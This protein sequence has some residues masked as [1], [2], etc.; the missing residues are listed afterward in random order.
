[1]AD[2]TGTVLIVDD[3][4]AVIEQLAAHFRRRNC[5]P[6][7]TA[8]PLIVEQSL[9]T[10]QIDLIL[11]D[12]RMERLNGYDVLQKLREKKMKI[13]ILIITAYYEDEKERLKKI[14][15]KQTDII[16]KPFQD[17]TKIEALINQKLNRKTGSS[18]ASDYDDAIY[19][20]NRTK[21]VLA[22][23]EMELCDVFKEILQARKYHLKTFT[24]GD[25]ALDYLLHNECHIAIID[26]KLPGLS[27]E[28]VIQ[29]A[30][31][32]KPHLRVIPISAAYPPEVRDLLAEIGFDPKKL[33][34]KPFDVNHLVKQIKA[35]AIKIGTLG[36]L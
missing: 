36:P 24:R 8:N 27:G 17:F 29:K 19:Y 18:E 31:H 34:T 9:Q 16:E 11:L 1:M 5:E 10:F 13:P 35:L 33:I 2:K 20:E 15:I 3:D 4:K 23:D 28:K 7:A 30:L 22:E 25:K 21:V 26:M 6:I 12:L 32:A 14:G